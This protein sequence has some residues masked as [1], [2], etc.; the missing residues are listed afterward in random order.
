MLSRIIIIYLIV[1][2]VY[3]K[4]YDVKTNKIEKFIFSIFI[5]IFGLIVTIF[6]EM[7]VIMIEENTRTN[8]KT[9]KNKIEKSKEFLTYIQS[10]ILD[11]LTIEDYEKVREII[12]SIQALPL[13]KQCEICQIAIG[14]KNVEISHIS[15]VS[16]MRI[17]TYFEKL[18]VHMESYTD[19]NK[20]E[21]IEKYINGLNNYLE[22]KL[23]YGSL[24]DNYIYKNISLLQELIKK[25]PDCEEKYYHMLIKRYLQIKQYSEATLY[26]NMLLNK[27]NNNEENYIYILNICYETKDKKLLKETLDNLK[28]IPNLTKESKNILEFWEGDKI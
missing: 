9:Q 16:L 19:L 21:N 23:V 15:A 20:V 12:L 13:K 17:K 26:A 6:S 25:K 14:S 3:F 7:K 18:F 22:C 2:L 24:K 5:P 28:N 11:N 8:L 4:I 27:Y 10:S 1:V